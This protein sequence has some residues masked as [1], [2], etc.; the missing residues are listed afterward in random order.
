M[1]THAKKALKV[2]CFSHAISSNIIIEFGRALS[3]LMTLSRSLNVKSFISF[4][5]ANNLCKNVYLGWFR[6]FE[7]IYK[8]ANF[9]PL[10]CIRRL[11]SAF[12][13]PH[14]EAPQ[15]TALILS[16]KRGPCRFC[17]VTLSP[18]KV[19]TFST[20]NLWLCSAK[21]MLIFHNRG[22]ESTG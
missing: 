5:G 12:V 4:M 15:K 8:L 2:S 14:P 10:G 18:T 13:F 6:D 16:G 17:L 3:G 19:S 9:K 7:Y 11:I 21:F 1:T 20:G 22:S